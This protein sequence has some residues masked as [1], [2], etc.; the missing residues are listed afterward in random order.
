MS[1]IKENIVSV[2]CYHFWSDWTTTTC[3]NIDLEKFVFFE[4]D[5]RGENS[6]HIIGH[7]VVDEKNFKW[8][9]EEL[10]EHGVVGL[11]EVARFIKV[12]NSYNKNQECKVSRFNNLHYFGGYYKELRKLFDIL[13]ESND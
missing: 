8:G 3:V 7:R 10:S 12:A 2:K 11:H 5:Y 6:W 4:I 13:E 9:T 1:E